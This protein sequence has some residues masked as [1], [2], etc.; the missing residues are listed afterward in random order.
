[1]SISKSVE[2]S[3]YG[4]VWQSAVS[5]IAALLELDLPAGDRLQQI[6]ELGYFTQMT[7]YPIAAFNAAVVI[8]L[9]AHLA[10]RYG[11]DLSDLPISLMELE[12][13]PVATVSYKAGRAVSPDLLRY[14]TYVQ[15]IQKVWK[16]HE[17]E[18]RPQ[19]ILEIGSG[20]GGLARTLKCFY[21]QSRLWL[22]DI[23]ES[24]RC[25]EIYLREAFPEA[26]IV[27]L[28]GSQEAQ[29]PEADFYLV[30]TT[31]E[32]CLS[33]R[34]FDL[35]INVWSFGEMP[36]VFVNAWLNLIQKDCQIDWLFT[37]NSFMAPVTPASIARTEIGDW[38]FGLD[39]QWSIQ[40]FEIDPELHRCPL[41]RNF[42]KGICLLARRVTDESELS[43]LQ[44]HAS[45]EARVVIQ[46]D[47]VGI[48]T[49][50]Q[51]TSSPGRPERM[52][53]PSGVKFDKM[54]VSSRRI[55]SLTDYIGH[56]NIEPDIKGAF[57]R[58]WND[59]RMNRESHSG[60]LL[61]A[62]LAMVGKADLKHRCT[63]EELL[64]LK[65]LPQMLLHEEYASFVS[66]TKRGEI[67]HDGAWLT[68][69][70]ACDLAMAHKT[71]GEFEA[72][73]NLWTKVAAAYPA[74]GDCWYQLAML[75]ELRCDWPMAAVFATHSVFLG[76]NC[77]AEVATRMKT[78]FF[79][80]LSEVNSKPHKLIRWVY[81]FQQTKIT[82]VATDDTLIHF[83]REYFNSSEKAALIGLS[84]LSYDSS[85]EIGTRALERAADWYH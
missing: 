24:L 58:L 59:Y 43:K 8:W 32:Q 80:S 35:A 15:D 4:D 25:A 9:E 54:V 51:S 84:K 48:A 61:V 56:F 75:H 12:A 2:K 62:Y 53:D 17:M 37:C 42:P 57:F 52:L 29:V 46:E 66:V 44:E 3:A 72:S 20:Y 81:R 55:I 78:A 18:M 83:C 16:C 73:R 26:K 65:R 67:A 50:V 19:N 14:V 34:S 85:D 76:C 49:N 22:A 38:L 39:N 77:Y 21:P 47:W 6:L 41:I 5:H 33:G 11:F 1:M 63:K 31:M 68:D 45:R 27:W 64:L 69:Q 60:A 30:P 28:N 7:S 70:E 74:H 71:V 82:E 36:N 40:H 10:S 23:P 13:A 79:R